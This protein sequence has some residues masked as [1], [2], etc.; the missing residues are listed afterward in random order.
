MRA[1]WTWIAGA[2][3]VACVAM[4]AAIPVAAQIGSKGR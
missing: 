1:L 3:V 4:C 2:P